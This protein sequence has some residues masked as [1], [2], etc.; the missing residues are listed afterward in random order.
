MPS[1]THPGPFLLL[2]A[3]G[4]GLA[5]A[6]KAL[7]L[8]G[9]KTLSAVTADGATVTLGAVVFTP[10]A[11]GA[12][13]FKVEMQHEAL[14]DH[15]LSMREFKCLPGPKEISCY[16]P[17]PY[18][19]PEQVRPGQLAWLEHSLLFFFK[20]PTDFGA[21]LWNGLYFVFTDTGPALVG[22][23]Q[24]VDLNLIGA[25]PADLSRPPYGPDKRHAIPADARW[26]R[27]LRIE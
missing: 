7:E 15:F 18:R 26:I 16:V 3:C 2:L 25:P 23:P 19:H 13:G 9:R 11:D 5:T 6:A 10:A 21:K 22:V 12:V 4:L 20:T 1:W 27:T 8:A 14:S 17:Y 24:A